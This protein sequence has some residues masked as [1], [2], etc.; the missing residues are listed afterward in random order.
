MSEELA[1]AESVNLFEMQKASEFQDDKYLASLMGN[2]GSYLPYLQLFWAQTE[3]V[4]TGKMDMNVWGLC[5][6]QDEIKSLGKN[7]LVVPLA[8]RFK[9]MYFKSTPPLSYFNPRS[10]EFMDFRRQADADSNS[11]YGY[12]PEFLLW[13]PG[14]GYATLFMS[15]KTSRNEAPAVKVLL[16]KADGSLQAG[17]LGSI[18]IKDEKHNRSW[19]GPKIALSDQTFSSP[20]SDTLMEVMKTFLK[21]I[22]S[23]KLEAAPEGVA[24]KDR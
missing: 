20:P 18:Y 14:E 3:Q 6:G 9:A 19:Q 8:F 24:D 22:D 10:Q 16:P 15:S 13:I 21:P 5:K 23:V 1:V 7:V 11:G 4:K 17:L 2:R 12:G